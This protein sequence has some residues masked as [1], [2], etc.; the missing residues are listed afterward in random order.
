[1]RHFPEIF[2]FPSVALSG[3]LFPLCYVEE[4][5]FNRQVVTV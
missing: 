3:Q 1:M 2:P 5:R 4:T